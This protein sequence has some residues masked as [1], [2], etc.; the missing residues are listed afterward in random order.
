[1]RNVLPSQGGGVDAIFGQL[2]RELWW[3]VD[4]QTL[5]IG[6]VWMD[7]DLCKILAS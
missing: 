5:L 4:D 7:D 3:F 2:W 1:M 6:M